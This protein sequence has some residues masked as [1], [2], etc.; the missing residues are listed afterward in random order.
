M[1]VADIL[2]IA[3]DPVK[4]T[5][6]QYMANLSYEQLFSYTR[7]LQQRGLIE[8]QKDKTWL[9]TERGKEYLLVYSHLQRILD[10][11]EPTTSSSSSSE[12][13]SSTRG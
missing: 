4:S 7:M 11:V 8:K 9:I 1:I 2:Q 13:N 5:Y 12:D 10:H 3:T 6:I